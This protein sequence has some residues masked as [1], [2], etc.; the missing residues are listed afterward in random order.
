MTKGRAY[1]FSNIMVMLLTLLGLLFKVEASVPSAV[2][3][4]VS[5]A[6][7]YMGANVADN[8]VKGKNYNEALN[9]GE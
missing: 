4:V 5:I 9:K 1:I 2:L 7:L 8:G 3:A 6:G